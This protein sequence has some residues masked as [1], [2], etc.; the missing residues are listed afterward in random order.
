M[1][2]SFSGKRTLIPGTALQESMHGAGRAGQK[3]APQRRSRTAPGSRSRRCTGDT[4]TSEEQ[5]MTGRAAQQVKAMQRLIAP[6]D[7]YPYTM[8]ETP[9]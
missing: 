9:R 4:T 8:T 6:S 1:D 5:A 3:G 7:H 2:T